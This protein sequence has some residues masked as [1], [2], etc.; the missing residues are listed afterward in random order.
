M[1]RAGRRPIN[2]PAD[3]ASSGTSARAHTDALSRSHCGPVFEA[4]PAP[5]PQVGGVAWAQMPFMNGQCW[6]KA[7]PPWTQAAPEFR[8]ELGAS[9]LLAM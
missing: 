7:A 9:F 3:R 5:Q 1:G 2:T 4:A 8:I 6:R